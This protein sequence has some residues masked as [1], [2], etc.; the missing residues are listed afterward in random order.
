MEKNICFWNSFKLYLL[1]AW[2]LFQNMCDEVFGEDVV[3]IDPAPMNPVTAHLK[4]VDGMKGFKEHFKA[5]LERLN[6]EMCYNGPD[7]DLV[8][9]VEKVADPEEGEQAYA[10]LAAWDVM[11]EEYNMGFIGLTTYSVG[12]IDALPREGNPYELASK[13][14]EMIL[15]KYEDDIMDDEKSH[16]VVL[17]RTPW[18]N[19]VFKDNPIAE[20]V[21]YRNVARRSFI[22]AI[23]DEVSEQLAGIIII[24]ETMDDGK[25]KVV[26]HGFVNPNCISDNQERVTG[27]VKDIVKRGDEEGMFDDFEYDNY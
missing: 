6:K 20:G 13:T 7:E 19:Q 23:H 27:I 14:D 2:V 24:D 10:Q 17:V 21:Y 3:D 1:E 26:C 12:L 16:F 25:V 15:K 18:N 9:M 4:F 8:S 22:N 11:M 5:R